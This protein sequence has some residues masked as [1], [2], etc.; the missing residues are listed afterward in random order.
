MLPPVRG[1]RLLLALLSPMAPLVLLS[2]PFRV[3]AA[4]LVFSGNLVRV[5]HGSISVRLV[6]RRVIDAILPH[7]SFLGSVTI[8]AEYKTG[9]QVRIACKPI[10]RVWE[11]ETSRYQYLE[12]TNLQLLPRPL[13]EERSNRLEF[14]PGREGV[15]QTTAGLDAVAQGQLEHAR[16]VNLAR[17]S[18]MPNFVADETAMRYASD[19]ASAKWRHVDTIQTEIAFKGIRVVRQRIRK[20]GRTWGRPFEALPG[21]KWYGGF[22]TESRPLFD[23]QCPTTIQYEGRAEV[24]GKQLLE[25]RFNSPADGCFGPFYFEYQRYNPARAGHFFIDDPG[26]NVIQLDEE[27]SGFPAEFEFAQRKEEISWDYVRIGNVSHLL[28]VGANFVVLYSTG[29]RWRVE[30]EYKNHRHFESSANV[31][32]K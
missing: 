28:P 19:S 15:N 8:A 31:V 11:E 17:A 12:V 24:R 16:E 5:G 3:S 9:D 18:N 21:F 14:P 7:K 26:G 23:P 10:Q 29:A 30:V 1:I 32:F 22:G 13:L 2:Q 20:N 25:Y 27:A 6:D 4:D